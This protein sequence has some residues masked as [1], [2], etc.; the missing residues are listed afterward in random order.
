MTVDPMTFFQ[1]AHLDPETTKELVETV[2]LAIRMNPKLASLPKEK[3]TMAF[4]LLG[5]I[6]ALFESR[7]CTVTTMIENPDWRSPLGYKTGVGGGELTD[8]L[9]DTMDDLGDVVGEQNG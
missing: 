6:A 8:K 2:I 7:G 9:D 4:E 3:L 1:V 5:C